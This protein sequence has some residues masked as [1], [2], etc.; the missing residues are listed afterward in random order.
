[1]HVQ[2]AAPISPLLS[3]PNQDKT[4]SCS[5]ML[6]VL[7]STHDQISGMSSVCRVSVLLHLMHQYRQIAQNCRI[8]SWI[9]MP[10]TMN[11]TKKQQIKSLLIWQ[12]QKHS[13]YCYSSCYHC[14]F[15]I[16]MA[17][18]LC[19]A[20]DMS[21]QTL[22]L[23]LP[24]FVA[25]VPKINNNTNRPTCVRSTVLTKWRVV[26]HTCTHLWPFSPRYFRLFGI[27]S[28]TVKKIQFSS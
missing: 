26:H 16:V 14:P 23:A 3:A 13:G 19:M 24:D 21:D 20:V 11:R 4:R 2:W 10:T 25:C 17:L 7:Y 27:L 5:H 28:L 15:S 6:I 22:T 18:Q 9:S 12:K 1:M 8:L